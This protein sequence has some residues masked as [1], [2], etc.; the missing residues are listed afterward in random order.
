M[1]NVTAMIGDTNIA[2]RNEQ[3][4]GR[5]VHLRRMIV[6]GNDGGFVLWSFGD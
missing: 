4:R 6:A 5:N 1:E 3:Y 2:F